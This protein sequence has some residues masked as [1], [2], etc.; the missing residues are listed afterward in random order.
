MPTSDERDTMMPP[1]LPPQAEPPQPPPI[2]GGGEWP[3]KATCD[4]LR[5]EILTLEKMARLI[6]DHSTLK[7]EQKFPG[8]HGEMIAQSMLAVRHLE[9]ARMRIGKVLQYERD[10]VS[11]LDQR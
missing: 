4:Y 5:S 11:I 2:P 7:G 9:D 3:L 8:Q 1:E 10:G 6:K